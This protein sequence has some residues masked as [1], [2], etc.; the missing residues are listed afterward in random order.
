M[1][2]RLPQTDTNTV[3]NPVLPRQSDVHVDKNVACLSSL[4]NKTTTTVLWLPP[5]T[6]HDP[7]VSYEDPLYPHHG[8][9]SKIDPVSSIRLWKSD[10]HLDVKMD[11]V[12]ARVNEDR[13]SITVIINNVSYS[14]PKDSFWESKERLSF[15]LSNSIWLN[16]ISRASIS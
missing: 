2:W 6:H 16:R 4:L 9:P 1:C 11:W 7:H 5:G 3:L 14:L 15:T 10:H 13:C 8:F 12:A